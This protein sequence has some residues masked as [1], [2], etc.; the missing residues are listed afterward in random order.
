MNFV[1]SLD[2]S[3]RQL[4]RV[5]LRQPLVCRLDYQLHLL[6]DYVRLNLVHLY[7]YWLYIQN[8]KIQNF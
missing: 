5:F 8:F 6:S 3:I 1:A 7:E 4:L 2:A